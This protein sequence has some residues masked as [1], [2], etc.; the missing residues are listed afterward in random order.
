MKEEDYGIAEHSVILFSRRA[1]MFK[2][3]DMGE[4]KAR[5]VPAQYEYF[6]NIDLW[7]VM[8][9]LR[10]KGKEKRVL[11]DYFRVEGMDR[12]LSFFDSMTPFRD[13]IL[14]KGFAGN[15]DIVEGESCEDILRRD[16]MNGKENNN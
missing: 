5:S 16:S 7:L 3:E 14:K 13:D 10:W 15:F 12:A 2:T 9:E 6:L 4:G 1:I 11:N 8:I